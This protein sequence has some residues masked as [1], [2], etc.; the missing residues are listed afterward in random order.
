MLFKPISIR[1]KRDTMRNEIIGQD[2]S[3]QYYD[4]NVSSSEFFISP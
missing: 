3:G 4:L 2:K 1:R